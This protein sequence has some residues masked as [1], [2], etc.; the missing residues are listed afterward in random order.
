MFVRSVKDSV[1]VSLFIPLV[2]AATTGSLAIV[3]ETSHRLRDTWGKNVDGE[4][5]TRMLPTTLIQIVCKIIFI[6]RIIKDLDDTFKSN[7]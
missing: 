5:V 7:S 6:V 4:M 3:D 1:A 2:L